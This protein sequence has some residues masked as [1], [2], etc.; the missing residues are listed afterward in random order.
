MRTERFMGDQFAPT[1]GIVGTDISSTDSRDTFTPDPAAALRLFSIT[2]TAGLKSG[3]LAMVEVMVLVDS[4][5]SQP[6]SDASASS[7]QHACFGF[8][9][10]VPALA[11]DALGTDC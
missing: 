5:L 8:M 1:R 7:A 9:T 4:P 10:P 2:I 3:V 6:A 11:P